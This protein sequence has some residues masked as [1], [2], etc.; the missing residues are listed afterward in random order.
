M[1]TRLYDLTGKQ[2]QVNSIAQAGM[3]SILEQGFCIM[4]I[5]EK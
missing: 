5:N 1:V 4:V 3:V 2:A